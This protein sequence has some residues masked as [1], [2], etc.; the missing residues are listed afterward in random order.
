MGQASGGFGG[1]LGGIIGDRL[2]RCCP[3]HG[4][5]LTAQISVL[6]EAQPWRV[7]YRDAKIHGFLIF[8]HETIKKESQA[9]TLVE[10]CCP[11]AGIPVAYLTFMVD[12]PTGLEDVS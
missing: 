5:P 3:L 8:C 12:P 9:L 2:S 1:L 7:G 10:F 11:R 6:S 4:R